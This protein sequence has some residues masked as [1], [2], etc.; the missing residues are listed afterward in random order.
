[1]ESLALLPL[2]IFYSAFVTEAET[3]YP[4]KK[5][6]DDAIDSIRQLINTPVYDKEGTAYH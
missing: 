5:T 1:M 3:L 4:T 6:K 2:L